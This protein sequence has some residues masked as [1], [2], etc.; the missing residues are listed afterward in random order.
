MRRSRQKNVGARPRA[1]AAPKPRPTWAP[2]HDA[3]AHRGKALSCRL[4]A[5]G[6]PRMRRTVRARTQPGRAGARV[7]A[8]RAKAG[9]RAAGS[10]S[11]GR[12]RPPRRGPLSGLK[13]GCHGPVGLRDPLSIPHFS[14]AT[15]SRPFCPLFRARLPIAVTM[16]FLPRLASPLPRPLWL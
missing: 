8:G 4:P 10:G 11:E 16:M 2:P 6:T 14:S 1:R 12:L 9:G 7:S 5:P 15:K 13:L 3:G